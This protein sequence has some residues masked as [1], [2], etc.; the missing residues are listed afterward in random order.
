M[1]KNE[2]L[3][4]FL[5]IHVDVNKVAASPPPMRAIVEKIQLAHAN[6]EA[7]LD[8]NK[9][10]A[11]IEILEIRVDDANSLATFY[12]RYA[13]K[14]G[15]DVYFVDP[16]ANT[17]RVERK[18][19]G[20]GRGYGAHF[21]LS[22][23]E[24]VDRPNIYIAML[25]KNTGLNATF[26][27]RLFQ[28]I[29]RE[30]YKADGNLFVCDD[31]SGARDRNGRPKQVGFRPMI[32]LRGLPS[33]QFIADLEN[34]SLQ[35]ILLIEDREGEQFGARPWLREKQRI[36]RVAPGAGLQQIEGLWNNLLGLFSEKARDGFRKARIKFKRAD[37][38]T[39]NAEIDAETG[40]LLD[41][42]YVKAKR[43][44]GINPALDECS[45][46]IVPHLATLIEQDVIANRGERA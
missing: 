42:R 34:G 40:A 4:Y 38:S 19:D 16:D 18:R 33:D 21:S 36:V 7:S 9:D 2:R 44:T 10:T 24:A 23:I 28:S 45:D 11:V 27:T 31:I 25:E 13:D 14:D 41:L 26:V 43:L 37:G 5:E 39:E 12:M 22:L 46:G 30:M 15:S 1:K 3:V 32:E 17:S 8:I 35:E 6:S 20:E 29:L